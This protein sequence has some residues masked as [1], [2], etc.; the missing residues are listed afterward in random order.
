MPGATNGTPDAGVL[1]F[2]SLDSSEIARKAVAVAVPTTQNWM[3]Y[4]QSSGCLSSCGTR[5]KRLSFPSFRTRN[6]ATRI[7]ALVSVT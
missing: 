6:T 7:L 1:I 4:C 3:Q 5:T 2:D